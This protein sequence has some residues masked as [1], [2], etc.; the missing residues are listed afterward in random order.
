MGLLCTWDLVSA[1][2]AL[3]YAR[4]EKRNLRTDLGATSTSLFSS[5]VDSDYRPW[6]HLVQ[7]TCQEGRIRN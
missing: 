6:N 2:L 1:Y 4:G 5:D 3:D 7:E